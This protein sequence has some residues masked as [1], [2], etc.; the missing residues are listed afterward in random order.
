MRLLL[1]EIW[2]QLFPDLSALML[3][4][5][6]AVLAERTE[7]P[8]SRPDT[9]AGGSWNGATMRGTREGECL[10]A[11]LWPVQLCWRRGD[12]GPVAGTCTRSGRSPRVAT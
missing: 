6:P 4:R 1:Y 11:Q 9:G 8:L 10:V 7:N 12:A 2:A 5:L 3:V